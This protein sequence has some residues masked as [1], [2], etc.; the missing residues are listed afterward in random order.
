MRPRQQTSHQASCT[1]S[2]CH[3]NCLKT[4][5]KS[6][7]NLRLF[8]VA[9]TSLE[10]HHLLEI[11]RAP[12]LPFCATILMRH[13]FHSAYKAAAETVLP[14]RRDSAFKEQGVL[15][16]EEFVLSGDHLVRTCPTWAWQAG[17][18]KKAR[19]YLPEDKQF[20]ITRNVPSNKRAAAVENYGEQAE[21]ASEAEAVDEEG[22]FST[23]GQH[24]DL[25]QPEHIPDMSS[26]RPHPQT[27]PAK[28]NPDDDIPDINDLE[29][30]DSEQPTTSQAG[31]STAAEEDDDI[32]HTRTYDLMI[33][34]DKYYQVPRFWLSGYDEGRQPL[35]PAQILEDVSEEHARKTITVDPF[36]HSSASAAS[37]HP[38][39]HAPVMRKLMGR[40][41]ADG[42]AFRVDDYMILFLK[43]IASVIPTI[44]YDYTMSAGW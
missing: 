38:C 22:W 14:V 27:A 8:S 3:A 13:A 6:L 32:M 41:E 2:D 1:G 17:D 16:P 18:P 10:P 15:T 7:I 37:I 20:L 29:L 9:A 12:A 30:D 23:P 21:Q 43:F 35:Q 28:A 11:L 25:G 19:A 4:N 40:A 33:T 36:P 26:E 39:K 31:P 24:P 44:Q 34:Y 5:H 42:R